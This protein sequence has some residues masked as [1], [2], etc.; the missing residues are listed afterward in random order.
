MKVAKFLWSSALSL[1][2][3]LLHWWRKDYQDSR[4]IFEQNGD[5]QYFTI[6]A[7]LQRRVVRGSIITLTSLS[8]ALVFLSIITIVLQNSRAR[9]EKSHYE[10]FNALV[11][12]TVDA[13]SGDSITM[14]EDQMLSLAQ[15]IRDR[16]I[17]IRRYVDTSTAAASQENVFLKTQLDSSGLT[18]KIVRIIQQNSPKGGFSLTD[19]INNHPLLRGKVADELATNRSLRDV[20]FALPNK[21]PVSDYSLTSDFGIRKHPITGL[22]QF[23][24]GMDLQSESGDNRVHP[25]KEGVVV[26]SQNH[27]QYGNTV[28]VLHTNGIES[29]YA[30]MSKLLVKVGEK[31][32][33]DSVLGLIGS[34]G[35]STGNHLHLEILVGGYP[36]NPQKVIWTAQHVQQIQIS[37]K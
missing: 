25:V 5:L 18:E 15:T 33:H 32:N 3:A 17:S 8:T 28:V 6:S 19:D 7:K 24:T 29:L 21:M 27:A 30:H 34:T 12:S 2:S 13:E 11:N 10:V 16:D 9:L 31:V 4:I 23:H 1:P 22:T 35:L 36:V 26:L 14:S 20:L 37:S